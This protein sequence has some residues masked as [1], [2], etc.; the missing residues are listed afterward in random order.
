MILVGFA[1]KQNNKQQVV[2]NPRLRPARDLCI[3]MSYIYITI[4]LD[5]HIYIYIYIT[6]IYIY[7]YVGQNKIVVECVACHKPDKTGGEDNYVCRLLGVAALD[8]GCGATWVSIHVIPVS[9]S[10]LAGIGCQEDTSRRRIL[11]M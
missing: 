8:L 1:P 2:L 10:S 6:Y 7:T 3:Y 4:Y 11:S 5:I 9:S